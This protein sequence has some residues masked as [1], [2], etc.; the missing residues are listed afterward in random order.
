[1][2]ITSL[3]LNEAEVMDRVFDPAGFNFSLPSS[4]NFQLWQRFHTEL[5]KPGNKDVCW[6]YVKRKSAFLCEKYKDVN[7]EKE[8]GYI[9]KS[10]LND[11]ILSDICLPIVAGLDEDEVLELYKP[12]LDTLDMVVFVD[13]SLTSPEVM[14]YNSYLGQSNL[15]AIREVMLR[16]CKRFRWK[17]IH[18]QH[19]ELEEKDIQQLKRLCKKR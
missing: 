4:G 7:T 2:M 10:G 15:P 18:L 5:K 16:L 3:T 9:L 12:V 17:V 8:C 13:R 14:R 19:R 6:G 11:F 1:M